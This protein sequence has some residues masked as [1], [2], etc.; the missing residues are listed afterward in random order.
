MMKTPADIAARLVA[1][2]VAPQAAAGF[3]ARRADGRWELSAGGATEAF[4]DLASLTK[5]MTALALARSGL[6]KETRLGAVVEEAR[7]TSS[8]DATL[9]L[10]LA[11]RAGLEAHVQLYLPLME[12]R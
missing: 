10:L 5:P 12:G 7:G 6:A 4:F 9:E 8:E 2:G 11:H 3:A 1:D